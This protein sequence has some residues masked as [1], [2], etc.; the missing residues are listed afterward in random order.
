MYV[1]LA[2][3]EGRKNLGW[4]DSVCKLSYWNKIQI[5]G[6]FQVRTFLNLKQKLL[7]FQLSV[8]KT[9]KYLQRWNNSLVQ[10]N[11]EI[12]HNGGKDMLY[13]T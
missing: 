13:A 1:N 3:V 12:F 9:I 7:C 4:H 11:T 6:I 2:K 8:F 10:K 5:L